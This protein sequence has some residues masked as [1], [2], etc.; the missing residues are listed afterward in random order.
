M[1]FFVWL[2]DLLK[3]NTLSLGIIFLI[4]AYFVFSFVISISV[5][6]KYRGIQDDLEESYSKKLEKFRSDILNEI[7]ET[8]KNTALVNYNEVNT[9]AIIEN[10][11]NSKMRT[12]IVC[13]RF[14]KHTVSML[15]T[16]GLLGTFLGLTLAVSSLAGVFDTDS[17]SQD[18]IKQLMPSVYGMAGA[19]TT[20]LFGIALSIV[21]TILTTVFNLE[22]ARET[23]MVRIEEYLDNTVSLVIAKD[24]QT[25]YSIMNKI[26]KETFVEFGDKIENTLKQT[27][28]TFGEKLT[29]VV[30]EVNVSSKALD[31]TVEKFDLSLK[32][33]AQNIKDFTDFNNNLK[34]NIEK[35]DVSFIKVTEALTS[36][37]KIIAENYSGIESFSNN[38]KNAA[39]EITAYNRQVV[40][41]VGVL[42]NEVKSTVSS[43]RELGEVVKDDLT[44]RT[45]EMKEYQDKFN[46]LMLK[47]SDEIN[48]LGQKTSEAFSQSL[49]ESGK[50]IAQNI[51]Q[52]M[53]NVLKEIFVLMDEFKEN[54]KVL[55]KTIITLPDQMLTYNETAAAQMGKQ[56]DEVKRLFRNIND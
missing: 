53:E 31:S 5:R 38:I 44:V 15:I 25:E 7:V 35:M 36:T 52:S 10:S 16:L 49:D 8:Y 41:D 3:L 11:F 39:E 43:I 34:N 20:S 6:S 42:V 45:G 19:F 12:L 4:V 17:F 22:E 55:A 30:M 1:Q 46:N 40:T 48:I 24:K 18:F 51:V 56:L 14:V 13:E 29:T 28:D 33:F 54:E 23:L 21:F 32:N 26:L 9:Q 37:S 2:E 50:I 47:L 27:V